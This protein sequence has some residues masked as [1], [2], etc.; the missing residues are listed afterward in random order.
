[1]LSLLPP[2]VAQP[3]CFRM[4]SFEVK[5]GTVPEQRDARGAHPLLFGSDDDADK[6]QAL[7]P[8]V[9]TGGGSRAVRCDYGQFAA[10]L[11]DSIARLSTALPPV[12]GK[13]LGTHKVGDLALHRLWA[14][15]RGVLARR[16]TSEQLAFWLQP[17]RGA[18]VQ[19]LKGL[20]LHA[21]PA[22]LLAFELTDADLELVSMDATT[23]QTALG[24]MPAW[25][26]TV[27]WARGCL[28]YTSDA[29]D[30]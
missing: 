14:T 4:P 8:G 3:S 13:R 27:E 26:R 12:A 11:L 16:P 17:Q 30:E 9:F 23:N 22:E 15:A 25:F 29:A 7:A 20:R 2:L 1:M 19:A 24:A 18:F 10:L 5:T 21:T 6:L 28:L